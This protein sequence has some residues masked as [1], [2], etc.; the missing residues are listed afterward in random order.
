MAD[1]SAAQARL[2]ESNIKSKADRTDVTSQPQAATSNGT[3]TTTINSTDAKPELSNAEKKKLAKAE[4]A[5]KRAAQKGAEVESANKPVAVNGTAGTS[6]D[7]DQKNTARRG[8]TAKDQGLKQSVPSGKGS[9]AGK[10]DKLLPIR[11]RQSQSTPIEVKQEKKQEKKQVDFFSHLYGQPRRHTIEGS[12]KDVHPAI[13]AFGLQL[14]SYTICGSQAR[15]VGMLL[16]LKSVRQL[17]FSARSVSDDIFKVI[18]SYTT[19]HGTSLPRHLSSHYLSPQLAHIKSA[20]PFSTTQANAIRWLKNLIA[21]IDPSVPE[22]VAK[23]E[24]CAAIDMF[25]RER[26]IV[27]DQVIAD[28]VASRIKN[29]DVVLTYAKSAVVQSALL[30]AAKKGTQFRVVTIDSRPLFEGKN[31]ARTLTA[32][33]IDVTYCLTPGLSHAAKDVTICLLGAH[34]MLG[35]GRLYSR[36]GTALVAM[37]VKESRVPVVVCAESIKFT[38]RVGLDSIVANELSPEEE[39]IIGNVRNSPMDGEPIKKEAVSATLNGWRDKENLHLLN[40]MYDV[41]PAEFIDVVVTEYGSLPPT[42]A[43]LIQR[44]SAGA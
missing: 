27:A 39:L 10:T 7:N 19:P 23:S 6:L 12:A 34:A 33:G 5:A 37:M 38:E 4:K 31:L 25:V 15:C 28:A 20:R 32:A 26:F 14:S 29:G 17:I 36:V 13:L 30:T 41:T 3:P 21:N 42:S 1:T 40:L 16:A 18:Q 22:D 43:P 8:S 11:R 9:Q 24:I 44:M 35:N 2:Q